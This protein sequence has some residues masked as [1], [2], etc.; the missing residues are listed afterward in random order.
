MWE[1]ASELTYQ[2]MLPALSRELYLHFALHYT[3]VPW[4]EDY[5]HRIKGPSEV[6]LNTAGRTSFEPSS[7][8]C[9]GV[10]PRVC[11]PLLET[12]HSNCAVDLISGRDEPAC[13][14]EVTPWNN[15]TVEISRLAVDLDEIVVS[16]YDNIGITIRCARDVPR[17][18]SILG[19]TRLTIPNGCSLETLEWVFRASTE[20][21]VLCTFRQQ[22]T[23]NVQN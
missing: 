11:R 23:G 17:H 10:N 3:G 8:Q 22:S 4:G 13:F 15:Q 19:P 12:I 7:E 14:L 9:M 16:S 5:V 6:A 2:V 21:Q 18:Q 1:T 20:V